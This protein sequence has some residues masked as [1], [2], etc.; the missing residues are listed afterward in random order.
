MGNNLFNADI[1]GKLAA[2]MGPLLASMS[3]IKVVPGTRS[4]TDPSAG[5]NPTRRTFP[6]KGILDSYRTSQFDETIIKRGDR[7]ALILG[8]TLPVGVI[9]E[10]N[11]EV[12]AEGSTFTVVAVERD[13]DAATY[14]CQ[15]R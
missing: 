8:N 1:A 11:D 9:P 6:C 2:A 10:P 13:P 15:V 7:K 3:L 14:T 12:K 4:P 5:T